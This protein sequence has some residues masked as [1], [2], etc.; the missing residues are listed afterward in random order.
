M[1]NLLLTIAAF[2][3]LTLAQ[4]QTSHI[5]TAFDFGFSPQNLVVLPGDTIILENQGYH[6]ITEVS[7]EDWNDNNP[8]SNG[9]FW[10]GIDAPT[11]DYWFVID[12]VG[13]YHYI[14]VPHAAMGMKGTVEVLDPALGIESLPKHNACAVVPKG[15]GQFVLQ[16]HDCEEFVVLSVSGQRQLS[17]S[18]KGIS[19]QT[20][21]DFSQL[22]PGA[23]L[24]VFVDNGEGVRVVKFIR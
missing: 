15:N 20:D 6:S 22:T 11:T 10:V 1:K 18:L 8:N 14:C 23:Y 7:E 4:G 5:I 9:G 12:E 19:N 21:V 13:L 2:T 17:K 3:F 24:G 16:F